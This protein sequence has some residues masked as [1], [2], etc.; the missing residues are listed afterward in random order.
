MNLVVSA[1]ALVCVWEITWGNKLAVGDEGI[2]CNVGSI[3]SCRNV[4]VRE[5]FVE[6]WLFCFLISEICRERG[7]WVCVAISELP[8]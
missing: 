1:G 5:M 8:G 4:T 2:S 7:V 3:C 6:F